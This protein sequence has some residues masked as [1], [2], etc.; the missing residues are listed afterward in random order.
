MKKLTPLIFIVFIFSKPLLSFN[1]VIL[2]RKMYY[3]S[4]ANKKEAE[5]FLETMKKNPNTDSYSVGYK[6]VA[7]MLMANYAFNP[8]DKL[9]YFSKGKSFLEESI[10]VNSVNV[11]LRFLRFCIQ[12]NAP[13]FLLYNSK[14][15]EDKKII[16]DNWSIIIDSDLKSKI[17]DYMIKSKEVTQQEKNI[18]K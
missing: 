5:L 12:T 6:G 8:Y 4:A 9:S 14:I 15:L 10:K 13:S 16:I 1:D 2:Y 7:Y 17:K 11:E 18:F 3:S